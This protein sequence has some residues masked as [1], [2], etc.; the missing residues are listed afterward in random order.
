M[1][2]YK[3]WDGHIKWHH[4]FFSVK[5]QQNNIRRGL[6][7]YIYNNHNKSK[8]YIIYLILNTKDSSNDGNGNGLY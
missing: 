4:F 1:K 8:I 5:A 6:K 7:R 3:E 2:I